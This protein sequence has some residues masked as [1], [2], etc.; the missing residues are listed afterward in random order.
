MRM[1]KLRPTRDQTSQI[2]IIC[3]GFDSD[4][5]QNHLSNKLELL[6]YPLKTIKLPIRIIRITLV[7]S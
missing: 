5:Y 2:V 6:Y 4:Y 7:T 3:R 1:K